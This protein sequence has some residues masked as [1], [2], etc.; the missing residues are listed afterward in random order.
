M[1]FPPL[2]N[3]KMTC[4]Y[5]NHQQSCTQ[6]YRTFHSSQDDNK[7]DNLSIN[8]GNDNGNHGNNSG[9]HD[10]NNGNHDNYKPQPEIFEQHGAHLSQAHLNYFRKFSKLSVKEA[11]KSMKEVSHCSQGLALSPYGILIFCSNLFSMLL[12]EKIKCLS[13]FDQVRMP[14]KSSRLEGLTLTGVTSSHG[15]SH[16][17]KLDQTIVPQVGP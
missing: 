15:Y 7:D 10:N 8:H 4:K 6:V 11:Q 2:I 16:T 12:F 3:N 5:C 1:K 9:N 14:W 13:N 17:F